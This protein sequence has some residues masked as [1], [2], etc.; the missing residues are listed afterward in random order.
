MHIPYKDMFLIPKKTSQYLNKLANIPVAVFV[1]AHQCMKCYFYFLLL[2]FETSCPCSLG[3]FKRLRLTPSGVT[4]IA[5]VIFNSLM[6]R[7]QFQNSYTCQ[8]GSTNV[9][10]VILRILSPDIWECRNWNIIYP[11]RGRG[12]FLLK[13]RT[14]LC[15]KGYTA[16]SAFLLSYHVSQSEERVGA[17]CRGVN[18]NF[19]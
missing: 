5:A 15:L 3:W 9:W 6:P 4:P 2:I 7:V 18:K 1:S 10:S 16:W 11:G 12:R 8:T 19:R 17:A 14:V 13:F